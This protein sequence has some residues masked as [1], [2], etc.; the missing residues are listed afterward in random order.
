[1]EEKYCDDCVIKKAS[2]LNEKLSDVICKLIVFEAKAWDF[3]IGCWKSYHK[4]ELMIEWLYSYK[5]E[6]LDIN[7]I[8]FNF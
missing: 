6:S 2:R 7:T 3:C 4:Q 8:T 1:M 5:K